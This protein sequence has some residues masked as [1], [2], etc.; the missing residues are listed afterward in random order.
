[1]N[2]NILRVF[3]L[4]LLICGASAVFF[5]TSWLWVA[6]LSTSLSPELTLVFGVLGAY[7]LSLSIGAWIASR[8]IA[9][10]RGLLVMLLS[11]QILD[12]FS[13]LKAVFDGAL[14]RVSGTL[15]LVTTVVWSTLL[16]VALR[17][18]RDGSSNRR[19]VE[20]DLTTQ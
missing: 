1:M 6:G 4:Y 20:A 11:S 7:L 17:I 5:P 8:D 19:L 2:Q 9:N 10:S 16:A 3:A 12:F 14:P 13:T 18:S 15:F